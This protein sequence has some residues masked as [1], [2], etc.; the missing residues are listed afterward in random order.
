MRQKLG[1]TV[2]QAV[3]VENRLRANGNIA[4]ELDKTVGS[5]FLNMR[6]SSLSD[7][8]SGAAPLVPS[9]AA[10]DFAPPATNCMLRGWR[11]QSTYRWVVPSLLFSSTRP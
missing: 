10:S 6:G 5:E 11:T 4:L 9:Y 3:V 1:E 7:S 8:R 2:G